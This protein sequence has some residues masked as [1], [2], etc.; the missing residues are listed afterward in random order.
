MEKWEEC[1]CTKVLHR[2]PQSVNREN[3]LVSTLTNAN[4]IKVSEHCSSA[5]CKVDGK[6]S[7]VQVHFAR[8]MAN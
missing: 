7:T 8:S 3:Y 2:Q 1:G 6:L 5:L 4:R